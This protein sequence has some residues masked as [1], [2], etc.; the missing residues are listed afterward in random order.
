MTHYQK[1]VKGILEGLAATNKDPLELLQ[2][3]LEKWEKA[4]SRRTFNLRK[5]TESEV[6]KTLKSMGNSAACGLDG[7]DATSLK[8]IAVHVYKPLTHLINLSLTKKVFP[9]RWKLAKILPLHKGKDKSH[10]TPDSYRPISLL[11]VTSKITERI[12]QKQLADFLTSTRQ[13]NPNQH[14]Y[15]ANHSTTRPGLK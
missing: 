13:L 4:D 5:A 9:N 8:A 1:K 15:R 14:A 6:L 12:V 7:Q 10:D 11:A 2:K 3:A